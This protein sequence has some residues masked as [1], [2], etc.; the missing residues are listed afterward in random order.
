MSLAIQLTVPSRRAW[1]SFARDTLD[2]LGWWLQYGATTFAIFGVGFAAVGMYVVNV[3][4]GSE[5]QICAVDLTVPAAMLAGIGTLLVGIAVVVILPVQLGYKKA[6]K[7]YRR[8]LKETLPI[9][10]EYMA[11]EEGIVLGDY[12]ADA[13]NIIKALTKRTGLDAKTVREML[14]ELKKEGKI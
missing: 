2:T 4:D 7:A 3:G 9:Y 5:N 12:P 11:S 13:E 1:A 14:D 6:A 8:S 10:R